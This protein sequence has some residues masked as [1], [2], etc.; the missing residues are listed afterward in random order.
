MLSEYN[1]KFY[2]TPNS[3]ESILSNQTLRIKSS[4]ELNHRFA[5]TWAVKRIK[6]KLPAR[7][8]QE[9]AVQTFSHALARLCTCTAHVLYTRN[10]RNGH[11]GNAGG[12]G[13]ISRGKFWA[14][15]SFTH[16]KGW[17][18]ES[19]EGREK[20]CNSHFPFRAFSRPGGCL[21]PLPVQHTRTL[22]YTIWHGRST[23]AHGSPMAP[24]IRAR[25]TLS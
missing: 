13:W 10:E 17:N 24:V 7:T 9:A 21:P 11:G 18:I 8:E 23:A 12:K 2:Q 6:R 20:K 16:A 25:H 3:S 14:W 19:L 1:H 4:Y 22:T 5:P 15:G